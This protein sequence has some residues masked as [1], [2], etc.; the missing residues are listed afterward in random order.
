M[1]ALRNW[2]YFKFPYPFSL[3]PFPPYITIELTTLCNL[4]CRHCWR[5]YSL[6]KR[7]V[8]SMAVSSFKKIIAE[9]NVSPHVPQVLK[10]GGAGEPALHPQFPELMVA[11][12]PL[13]RRSVHTVLYTNGTLLDRFP[14]QEIMQWNIARLVVSVDGVDQQSYEQIRVGGSY[15][16]LRQQVSNFREHRARTAPQRPWIEIRHVIMPGETLKHLLRFR[17]QWIAPRD[18]VKFQSLMDFSTRTRVGV[19]T[20]QAAKRMARG[21]RRELPIEWDGNVPITDGI[22]RFAGNIA[23]HTIEELWLRIAKICNTDLTTK[24]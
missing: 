4:N 8:G 23:S 14:P 11:L 17:R 5:P 12:E 18:T 24:R 6:Q 10:I 13:K 3:P 2:L 7:G 19:N 16:R 21:I 1:A 15:C 20:S 9:I 22:G